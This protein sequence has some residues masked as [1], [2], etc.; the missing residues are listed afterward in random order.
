MLLVLAALLGCTTKFPCE[1]GEWLDAE[2]GCHAAPTE[3]TGRPDGDT[4]SGATETAESAESG[5]PERGD[6]GAETADT[7]TATPAGCESACDCTDGELCYEGT[8]RE[9]GDALTIY[10]RHISDVADAMDPDS[11]AF[12][13]ES[14]YPT[15]AMMS[16][17]SAAWLLCDDDLAEAARTRADYARSLENADHLMYWSGYPYLTRDYNAR[18]IYNLWAAGHALDDPDLLEAADATASTMLGLERVAHGD[19]VLFCVAYETTAPYACHDDYTWIDVNQNSE[20]GLAFALLYTDPDSALYGDPLALDVALDELGAATSLQDAATGAIPIGEG[21]YSDDYDTLYGSYAAWSWTLANAALPALALDDAV[22]AAADWLA[23]LSDDSPSSHR[24][25]PYA[26]DGAISLAEGALRIP[27][28]SVTGRLDPDF[29]E[30]YWQDVV[31]TDDETETWLQPWWLELNAGVPL[32]EL[33]PP[34][35]SAR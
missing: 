1:P 17:A 13:S 20:V 9:A 5:S 33:F 7:D 2:G 28:L 6:S 26:Y 32:S 12:S 19:H 14:A 11:G 27:T 21:D 24:T 3:E 35:D 10:Q 25:W 30:T 15:E 29:V 34:A 23:P 22:A 4:R 8:C 18:H 31:R 16:L